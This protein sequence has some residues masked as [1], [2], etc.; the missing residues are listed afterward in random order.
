MSAF[1][2]AFLG[3][4]LTSIGSRDQLLV[5]HL[6]GKLGRSNALLAVGWA[7][8]I[9]SAAVMAWGG[10]AVAG[11]L[12]PSAKSM[13]VAMALFLAAIELAWKIPD[14]TAREPT[15]SL[16]PIAAV[17][18]VRQLSD[19]G[20]FLVFAIAAAAPAAILSGIGGAIGGGAAITLGWLG[21]EQW[22]ARPV[23]RWLRLA[24]A[25]LVLVAATII[26]LS[27]RGLVN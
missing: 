22:A 5:A 7:I 17:L 21:A 9:V 8:S 18:L 23:V 12:A 4:L 26:A 1:F 20:R 2:L 14:F 13:L 25:A 15:R 27:A 24:L 19:A 3:V 11:M 10:H 6:A 16:F